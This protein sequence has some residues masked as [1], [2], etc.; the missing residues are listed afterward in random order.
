MKKQLINAIIS[1]TKISNS[2]T[3]ERLDNMSNTQ[4]IHLLNTIERLW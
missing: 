2:K 1:Q 4:L 3:I